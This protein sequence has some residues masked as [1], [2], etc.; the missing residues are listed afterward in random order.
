MLRSYPLIGAAI[1]PWTATAAAAEAGPSAAE[2]FFDERIAPILSRHCLE[3]HDTALS[4]G[5]LDLSLKIHAMAAGEDGPFIV[6]GDAENSVLWKEIE[7]DNMPEDRPALSAEQKADLK[8]WI[9]EGAIWSSDELDPMAHTRDPRAARNWV[10]RLT[11]QEYLRTVKAATG[12]DIS[13]EAAATLP[14]ELRAD[15]F[16]NTAYSLTIDMGH[17]TA[18]ASLAA[19]IVKQMDL[20]AFARAHT[21]GEVNDARLD[22]VI[23][24]MGR[25]LARRPLKSHELAA[26]QKIAASVKAENGTL[27]EILGH[28][29]EAMLQSPAFLYRIETPPAPGSDGRVAPYELASRLSYAIQGG[30]PDAGLLLAAETGALLEPDTLKAQ[31]ARMVDD[32]RCISRSMEFVAQWLN[33]G[34][35][36]NLRPNPE[37]FP[38]WTAGLAEGMKE[39]TLGF[40]EEIA[41]KRQLPLTRLFNARVTVATPRLAAHYQLPRHPALTKRDGLLALYE[42]DE[43]EGTIIRDR[44]GHED[45]L[46][47]EISDPSKIRWESGTL[48]LREKTSIRSAKPFSRAVAAWKKS[49][50]LTLEAWVESADPKQSGPARLVTLSSG[51]GERNLTLGQDGGRYEMRVRTS[52]IGNN[53]SPGL[54]TPDRIVTPR[55]NHLVYTRNR[56]RE[57]RFYLDGELIATTSVAGNFNNW[58]DGFHLLLGNETTGDRPWRGTYHRVA[59][60]DRVLPPDEIFANAGGRR[61]YDLADVPERGGLLTQ[62]SLLTI[63]GDEASMVTR[64]LFVLHDVLHSAVGSPPPGVD[65][66]PEPP[67]PGLS[68]RGM[69]IKRLETKSCAGC[70]SKFEPLAFGLE[71][72]DGI[73]GYSSKDRHGNDLREDGT[74]QLPGQRDPLPFKT[75]SELMDLLANSDRVSRNFTRKL[76]QFTLGRPLSGSDARAIHDIHRRAME[77]GGT[78]RSL[79]TAIATSDLLLTSEPVAAP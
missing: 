12:V 33:L 8:K 78:Y 14:A 36:A 65:T 27:P 24:G 3:C 7:S 22:H 54:Q 13:R 9:N 75:S 62:G 18:Y 57:G 25:W 37:K 46:D 31:V 35:L 28:V 15:G 44:S 51:S 16:S 11:N 69:A 20:M 56:E 29:V 49:Q 1:A 10:Q 23:A 77:S 64:G 38:L 6:P 53:G 58:N 67:K 48:T 21:A 30:P 5:D 2:R 66:T 74:L 42:F 39:E 50:E 43:G 52:E 32:P 45:P 4:K 26:Y 70:H 68:Q 41:W 34:R 71:K 40:F 59:L 17:V 72:F 47:L 73:G 79:I 19:R 55:L 60:Y 63:G 76:I 61:L